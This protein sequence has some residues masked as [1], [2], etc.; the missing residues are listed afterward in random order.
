VRNA[1][2]FERYPGRLPVEGTS[3]PT[4]GG[5]LLTASCQ[6]TVLESRP[7]APT[8]SSAR[9]I[10][11]CVH[12]IKNCGAQLHEIVIR[13]CPIRIRSPQHRVI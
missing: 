4:I 3:P 13:I 9:H 12:D 8:R 6:W 1:E 10:G 2:C 5:D 7:A 11:A